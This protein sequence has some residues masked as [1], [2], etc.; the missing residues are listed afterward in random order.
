MTIYDVMNRCLPTVKVN[1]Q[2]LTDGKGNGTK[3]IQKP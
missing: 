2:V 3:R 1:E